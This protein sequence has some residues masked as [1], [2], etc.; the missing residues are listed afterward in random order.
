MRATHDQQIVTLFDGQ[1]I[2][3]RHSGRRN[4][5][6]TNKV[7][8]RIAIAF[9]AALIGCATAATA[10]TVKHQS[11]QTQRSISMGGANTGGV[12]G[13]VGFEAALY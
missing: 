2:A 4:V 8:T 13:S 11:I 9:A 3:P 5:Q 10:V 7:S 1:V 12:V 6:I